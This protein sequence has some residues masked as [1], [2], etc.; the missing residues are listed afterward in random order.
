LSADHQTQEQQEETQREAKLHP[1]EKAPEMISTP[2][3]SASPGTSPE[4]R[5]AFKSQAQKFQPRRIVPMVSP[6]RETPTST[7]TPS[8]QPNEN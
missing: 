2:A 6:I 7:P 3:S 8:E 4:K 5:N 1:N